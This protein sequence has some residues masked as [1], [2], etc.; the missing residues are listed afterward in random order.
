[1]LIEEKFVSERNIKLTFLLNRFHTTEH[2][3]FLSH[4]QQKNQIQSFIFQRQST[5]TRRSNL[6][7]KEQPNRKTNRSIFNRRKV[8]HHFLF[9]PKSNHSLA[10]RSIGTFAR[11]LDCPTALKHPSLHM[12]AASASRD[13]T[14]VNSRV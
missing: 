2:K 1:M 12:S 14:L 9:F 4:Q 11:A 13:A 5:I 8:H 6:E 3:V 10:R 7:S